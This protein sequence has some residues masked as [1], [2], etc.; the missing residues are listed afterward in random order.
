MKRKRMSSAEDRVF[1][2]EDAK[3]TIEKCQS[4]IKSSVM[5]PDTK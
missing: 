1:Y 2:L 3:E 5:L 4:P